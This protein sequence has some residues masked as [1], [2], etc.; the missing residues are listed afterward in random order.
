MDYDG[1]WGLWARSLLYV[2]SRGFV[3]EGAPHGPQQVLFLCC[4]VT[5]RLKIA[6]KPQTIWSL[7]PKASEHES[8][9]P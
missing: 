3:T 8:L 1:T 4:T 6:Q 7:G 2:R 9:E 5:Q